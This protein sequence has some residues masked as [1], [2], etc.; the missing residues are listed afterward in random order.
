[1]WQSS[2]LVLGVP[3]ITSPKLAFAAYNTLKSLIFAYSALFTIDPFPL[4]CESLIRPST[5][6]RAIQALSVLLLVSSVCFAITDGNHPWSLLTINQLYLSL[7]LGL[8][9]LNETV[10]TEIIPVVRCPLRQPLNPSNP[11]NNS[12]F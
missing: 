11:R 1:M 2:D 7:F 5:M 4:L 3:R 6:T 10:Q 12:G 9:P 8:V